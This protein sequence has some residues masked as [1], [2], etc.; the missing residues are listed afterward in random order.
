MKVEHIVLN[1]RMVMIYLQAQWLN[2]QSNSNKDC[3]LCLCTAIVT[4]SGKVMNYR[5]IMSGK[6]G[7]LMTIFEKGKSKICFVSN[8]TQEACSTW[9]LAKLDNC[10]KRILSKL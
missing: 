10:Q 2:Q 6:D 7:T 4:T 3:R 8:G 5:L 1:D 9:Y